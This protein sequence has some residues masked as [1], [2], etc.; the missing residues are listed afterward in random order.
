MQAIW[1]ILKRKLLFFPPQLPEDPHSVFPTG[2]FRQGRAGVPQWKS[3]G[4]AI[5][6]VA[7]SSQTLSALAIWT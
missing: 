5:F 6:H 7:L 4:V 1:I 2:C 3:C